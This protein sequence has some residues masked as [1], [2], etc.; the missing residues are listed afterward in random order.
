MSTKTKKKVSRE[1]MILKAVIQRLE[2]LE[3]YRD[4]NDVHHGVRL[5]TALMRYEINRARQL[6]SRAKKKR[7]K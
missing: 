6:T 5:A 2:L 1:A 7:T 4:N 3:G